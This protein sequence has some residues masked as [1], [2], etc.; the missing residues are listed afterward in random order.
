MK[1]LRISASLTTAMLAL[2]F[3]APVAWGQ[4]VGSL[5][6]LQAPQP[7]QEGSASYVTGG[8]GEDER[9]ALESERHDYDLHVTNSDPSGAFMAD[10][11]ITIRGK[12]QNGDV[13]Q[14]SGTGPLFYAQLPPGHYTIQANNG[15]QE[16]TRKV[17]ISEHNSKDV[18][19]VW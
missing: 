13:I 10:T 17:D 1:S 2:M 8:I 6:M 4:N 12:G 3:S 9:A 16:I 19:L 5:S 15:G 14:A 18:H 11:S 7:V